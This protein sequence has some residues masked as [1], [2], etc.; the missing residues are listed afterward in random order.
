MASVNRIRTIVEGVIAT[1]ITA[2]MIYFGNGLEPWWPLMWLAPLP[3]LVFALR[4]GGA[5]AA[6]AAFSAMLLG[7]LNMWSYFTHT[8]GMPVSLWFCIFALAAAMFAVGVLLFRVLVLRGAVWSGVMALPAMLVAVEYLRN[9]LTP[10]GSAGSLAYSQLRFLPFL[11][12]ASITGPWGMTFVLLLFSSSLAAAWHLRAVSAKRAVQVAAVGVGTVA[13]VLAFGAVRLALPAGATAR[14]G[15]MVSDAK[16]HGGGTVVDPFAP[17]DKLFAE[18]ASASQALVQKGAQAIVIPEKIAVTIEGRSAASDAILQ[19]LA[20]KSETTVV[21]GVVYVDGEK[22]Y[23]EARVYQPQGAMERYDKEHML[24]P[25]ESPLT[26]G[27]T[28]VTLP[29]KGQLWGVAICKDM[30]FADPARSYGREGAGLMLVPAWDFT[31]DRSWHGHIAVMR[32]VEDG[33]SIARSAKKGYLTVS[34][35]RG[36]I[37]AERPSGEGEF[38]TLLVDVP[39]EHHR[40]VYQAMGDWF[41][42]VAIALLVIALLRLAQTRRRVL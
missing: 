1:A 14:V 28:L 32:G 24:P 2:L 40:T 9:L 41:A 25:F 7:Y 22:K 5:A 37:V 33:F 13:L 6:F 4:S 38:S 17:T 16:Q 18:Y 12:L 11:Q 23:N 30:D 8:I 10:H 15:L 19:A 42:W 36:R 20:D 3:V 29:R 21:A 35:W 31:V 26:P 27:T 39:A 34:D